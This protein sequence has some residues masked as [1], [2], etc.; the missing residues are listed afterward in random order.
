[1]KRSNLSILGAM[2]AL[3]LPAMAMQMHATEPADAFDEMD[4]LLDRSIDD[5]KDLPEFKVP[6]TG[7]YK[8][9]VTVG[10]KFINDKPAIECNYVV[11][12]TVELADATATPAMPGDKFSVAFFLKDKDGQPSEMGEGRM[13]E[14]AAPFETHFG[15]KHLKTLFRTHMNTPVDITAKVVKKPRKDDKT[16][17]N[18]QVEDITV[19]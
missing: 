6:E 3:A 19:D 8:L 4:D 16:I 13:K 7:V 12:E 9:S 11:R 10:A 14:F 18:A 15:E 5:L 17:F 2:L 1:M